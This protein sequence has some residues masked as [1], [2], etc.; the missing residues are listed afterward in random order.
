[1]S[2]AHG[3]VFVAHIVASLAATVILVVMRTE[4]TA[5]LSTANTRPQTAQ[6]NMAARLFHLIPVTGAAVIATSGGDISWSESWVG[7][8]FVLYLVGAAVLEARAL[9]AERRGDERAV[10]RYVEWSLVLLAVAA[11]VMLVQF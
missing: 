2:I 6:R 8:G 3:I 5:R 1:M 4:A 7:I 10:I 11:L 9:P